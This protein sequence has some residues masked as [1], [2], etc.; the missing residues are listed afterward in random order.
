MLC[1]VS[2]ILEGFWIVLASDLPTRRERS[3]AWVWMELLSLALGAE[4]TLHSRDFAPHYVVTVRYLAAALIS[5]VGETCIF[6]W[7][8]GSRCNSVGN[9]SVGSSGC[10]VY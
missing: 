6:A 8:L 2:I 10:L 3:R 4:N 7:D 5:L 1:P 9:S